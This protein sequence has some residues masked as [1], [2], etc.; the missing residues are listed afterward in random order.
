MA[1]MDNRLADPIQVSFDLGW[2]SA[3][4]EL[5]VSANPYKP[6]DRADAW[7]AGYKTF[8]QVEKEMA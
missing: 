2:S 8:N 3:K 6:G 5:T 1:I 7:L 4:S